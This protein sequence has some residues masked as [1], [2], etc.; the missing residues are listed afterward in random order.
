MPKATSRRVTHPK[1]EPEAALVP[2]TDHSKLNTFG[3]RVDV[4]W[5][6]RTEVTALGPLGYFVQFLKTTDL[7][8]QWV[9]E[10]PLTYTSN[11]APRKAEILGA[12]LLSI[13]S[14]HKRYAHSN[15]LH[16]D[17]VIPPLLGL[18]KLPS[19]GAVRHAFRRGDRD[20]Y[21]PWMD[22]SLNQTFEPLLTEPLVLEIDA[23]VKTLFGRQEAKVG[24]NPT[25]PGRPSHV[26][27]AYCIG[28][29]RMVLEVEVQAG[30]QTAA[31]FAHAGL[32]GWLVKMKR[33]TPDLRRGLR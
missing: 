5:D 19:E 1:G 29:L 28:A 7:W 15:A 16:H 30:N 3:G 9:E 2:P 24:Y 18:N 14:G 10:C 26:Y 22:Q 6:S 8:E 17:S 13:L 23:T 32:F 4:L 21:T 33:P 12:I 20:P 25:K 11:N 31:E 27:H